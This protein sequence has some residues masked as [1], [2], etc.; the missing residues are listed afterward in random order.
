MVKLSELGIERGLRFNY[1]PLAV[2]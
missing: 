1:W 2:M